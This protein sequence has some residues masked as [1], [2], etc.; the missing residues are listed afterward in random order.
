M[1][2]KVASAYEL[3]SGPS[4]KMGEVADEYE[5]KIADARKLGDIR[6]RLLGKSLRQGKTT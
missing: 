5:Q 3:W 1:L 6:K 2:K 4:A